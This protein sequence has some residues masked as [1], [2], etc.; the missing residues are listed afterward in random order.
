MDYSEY[1]NKCNIC[2]EIINEAIYF[3]ENYDTALVDLEYRKSCDHTFHYKCLDS[4]FESGML[5]CP[6]CNIPNRSISHTIRPYDDNRFKNWDS[7]IINDMTLKNDYECNIC[8]EKMPNSLEQIENE[9]CEVACLHVFHNRCIESWFDLG[10]NYCP[11]C[12]TSSIDISHTI[13]SVQLRTEEEHTIAIRDRYKYTNRLSEI[14]NNEI[15]KIKNIG[16]AKYMEL[17]VSYKS[18][19]INGIGLY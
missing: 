14:G 12:N 8:L 7:Y 5:H 1:G 18:I 10:N 16:L 6:I 4:W 15:N 3:Y 9:Y 13:Q 19:D 2:L 17:F 11:V